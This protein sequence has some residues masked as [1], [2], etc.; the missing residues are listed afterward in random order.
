M[1]LDVEIRPW[2]PL[3]LAVDFGPSNKE[4]RV[5]YWEHIEFPTNRMCLDPPPCPKIQATGLCRCLLPLEYDGLYR[6]LLLIVI[7]RTGFNSNQIYAIKV[8]SQN[9]FIT[10]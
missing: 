8:Q 2:L 3:S 7:A 10:K 1:A 9:T 4:I 6:R 5:R